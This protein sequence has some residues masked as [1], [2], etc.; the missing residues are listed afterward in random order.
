MVTITSVGMAG[1]S[2]LKNDPHLMVAARQK[3]ISALCVTNAALQNP[4]SART[5][6]TLTAVILLGIFEV[7]ILRYYEMF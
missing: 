5:D 2:N 6:L 4:V 1:I 3:Y 7:H